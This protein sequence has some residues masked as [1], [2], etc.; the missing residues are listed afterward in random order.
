MDQYVINITVFLLFRIQL[1][2]EF[3]LDF[4]QFKNEKNC[5]S[6]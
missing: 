3:L 2:G 1:K 4:C 5:M 6:L